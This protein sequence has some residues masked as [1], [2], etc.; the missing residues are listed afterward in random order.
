MYR[1]NA[2]SYAGARLQN[3]LEDG[4]LIF[5]EWLALRRAVEPDLADIARLVNQLIE[6]AELALS[7]LGE[8]RMQTDRRTNALVA[9]RQGVGPFPRGRR[10]RHA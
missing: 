1:E 9:G 7:L 2:A 8:L 5:P 4:H 3:V 10:R 6:L